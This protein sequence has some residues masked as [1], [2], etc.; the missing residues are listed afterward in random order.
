[1]NTLL[2]IIPSNEILIFT[3]ARMNITFK[4]DNLNNAIVYVSSQRI[5]VALS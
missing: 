5:H 2:K 1:M 4:Y 3:S